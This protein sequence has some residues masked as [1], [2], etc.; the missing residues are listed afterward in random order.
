MVKMSLVSELLQYL[1][2]ALEKWYLTIKQSNDSLLK[3]CCVG[4]RLIKKKKKKERMEVE[5]YR[6]VF[7]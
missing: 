1:K 2:S 7:I 3:M 6:P 5:E 4:I